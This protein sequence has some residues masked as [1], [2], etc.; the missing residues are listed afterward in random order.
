MYVFGFAKW[1]FT[2]E[3]I[4][5]VALGDEMLKVQLK[6]RFFVAKKYI[7]KS[8]YVAFVENNTVKLYEHDAA[9]TLLK[10]NIVDSV[11]WTEKGTYGW[12]KTPKL[13]N[14]IIVEL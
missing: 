4:L 7:G 14:D 3:R 13:F 1:W 12:R 9:I 8:I 11:S 5:A 10:P 2:N 6:G